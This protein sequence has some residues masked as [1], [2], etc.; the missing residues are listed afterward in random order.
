MIIPLHRRSAR[1][2]AAGAPD[3]SKGA[4][5]GG[6][7]ELGDDGRSGRLNP[8]RSRLDQL[9]EEVAPTSARSSSAI[10]NFEIPLII[11]SPP[12]VCCGSNRNVTPGSRRW[13]RRV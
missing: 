2:R 12:S 11:G 8:P 5:K 9:L 6:P 7:R 4:T 10:A 13:K 3:K 1:A